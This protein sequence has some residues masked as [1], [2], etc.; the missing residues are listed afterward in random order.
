M[1]FALKNAS[2]YPVALAKES[3]YPLLMVRC[4]RH[5]TLHH[6]CQVWGFSFLIFSG[7][8]K[9]Y[10]LCNT[11]WIL[12]TSQTAHDV[13]W[14]FSRHR[15]NVTTFIQ[16]LYNFGLILYAALDSKYFKTIFFNVFSLLNVLGICHFFWTFRGRLLEKGAFNR[17]NTVF[18][19]LKMIFYIFIY[20][21]LFFQIAKQLSISA[22]L[23]IT[24]RVLLMV[25]ARKNISWTFRTSLSAFPPHSISVSSTRT[26]LT[27][28]LEHTLQTC[29][30]SG[31]IIPN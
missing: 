3:V 21:L 18:D 24:Q 13:A 7:V 4:K 12:S 14:T 31:S 10:M 19:F 1:V 23:L 9:H 22:S 28:P 5:A 27:F 29:P 26:S 11:F 17:E 15:F 8:H 2:V 16:R 6:V 30:R 20:F 25:T